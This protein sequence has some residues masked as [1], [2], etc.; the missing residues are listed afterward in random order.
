[1]NFDYMVVAWSRKVLD[2]VDSVYVTNGPLSIYRAD[3]IR[4]IG[5]FD[6]KNLTEDIEITWHLLSL[7]YKTRMSYS[8]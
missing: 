6:T 1:M 3:V 7:G 2:F 4:K 8:T 5:G